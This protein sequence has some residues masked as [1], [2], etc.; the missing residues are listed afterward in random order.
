LEVSGFVWKNKVKWR[1][2]KTWGKHLMNDSMLHIIVKIDFIYRYCLQQK[3]DEAEGSMEGNK[4]Y[5]HPD[6]REK[7][8]HKL[9]TPAWFESQISLQLPEWEFVLMRNKNSTQKDLKTS[10]RKG[11]QY[12]R[13]LNKKA[14]TIHLIKLI[15]VSASFLKLF[16]FVFDLCDS[17]FYSRSAKWLLVWPL[18][19]LPSDRENLFLF[20]SSF[21][22]EVYGFNSTFF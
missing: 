1:E 10:A 8:F 14:S 11:K 15:S 17:F 12:K 16:P 20:S 4:K 21:E 22:W 7:R 2:R 13:A 9:M 3:D 18:I 19:N 6:R 5:F